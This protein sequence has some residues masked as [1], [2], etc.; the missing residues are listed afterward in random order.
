VILSAQSILKRK[1][2]SP[3]VERTVVNGK[4]YGISSAGYDVR[5]DLSVGNA[6]AVMSRRPKPDELAPGLFMNTAVGN[7]NDF[8][9]AAT[10]EHFNMPDDVLGIV[11][12]KSS[13]ARKGLTVQNTVIE[14]GWR[15]Y[16]TLELTYHG[17]GDREIVIQHGDPIAQIV[18]HQLDE[19]TIFPYEGKYQ[20]QERG[21]QPARDE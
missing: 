5:V 14:P 12:D 2:I 17:P 13:W 3:S 9:L 7:P 18:F 1:I 11:H 21:P 20:D 16:L 6:V 4:S 8:M 15:G 10:L 19:P